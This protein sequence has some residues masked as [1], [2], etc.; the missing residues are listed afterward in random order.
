L[1][2]AGAAFRASISKR[3]AYSLKGDELG[4]WWRIRAN[5]LPQRVD[6]Q[7]TWYS[8]K[9][10][11]LLQAFGNPQSSSLNDPNKGFAYIVPTDL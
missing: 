11:N 8:L 2:P 3:N 4:R 5:H 1:P 10:T 7:A 6:I 9:L